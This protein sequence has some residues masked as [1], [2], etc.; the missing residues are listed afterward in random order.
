MG[1]RC[2]VLSGN[3]KARTWRALFEFV[4]GYGCYINGA[5][6]G[7]RTHAPSFGGLCG[8]SISDVAVSSK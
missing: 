8:T 7:I 6:G 3:N 5:L 1:V 2:F 4:S